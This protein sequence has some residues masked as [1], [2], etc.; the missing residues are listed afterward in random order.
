MWGSVASAPLAGVAAGGAGGARQAGAD[1]TPRATIPGAVVSLA[2]AV[3]D[4]VSTGRHVVAATVASSDVKQPEK[5]LGGF[6]P[7]LGTGPAG[8]V[9][10]QR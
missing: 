1:A 5:G 7:E 6:R 10:F 9:T 4:V 3:G 8:P 2:L